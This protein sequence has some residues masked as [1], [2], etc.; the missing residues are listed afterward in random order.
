MS[1]SLSISKQSTFSSR[2][3]D[4]AQ[5]SKMRLSLLVVFSAAC[6]YAMA[7]TG[8]MN[9]GGFVLIIIGGFLVTASANAFNQIIE[10]NT[11]KLM[12]R[13]RNRPLPDERMSVQE[14][15]AAALI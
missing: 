2:V 14:A 9:W 15:L 3:A 10:K 6:A 4:Y 11:D 8:S 13:T 7:S 1:K 12:D 5:L